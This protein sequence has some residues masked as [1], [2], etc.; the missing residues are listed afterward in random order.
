MTILPSGSSSTHARGSSP[1]S[2][3]L[4]VY[5]DGSLVTV[6]EGDG[7]VIA[8]PSGS[9]AYSMSAGGE[10][11]PSCS[12]AGH[13]GSCVLQPPASPFPAWAVCT[14]LPCT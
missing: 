9:T 12:A 14:Y 13:M 6:A 3:L 5:I 11:L 4:E 2:L 7:L 8:T 1:T 10:K